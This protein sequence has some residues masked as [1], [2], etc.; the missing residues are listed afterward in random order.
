MSETVLEPLYLPIDLSI[1]LEARTADL[2]VEGVVTSTG[3]PIVNAFTGNDVQ[4]G[5]HR[6][7]GIEYRYAR[8]G[9]GN[10]AATGAIDLDFKDT[11]AHFNRLY[12]NQDGVIDHRVPS[13]A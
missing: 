4:A 2:A 10:A 7:D 3:R 8:M 11:Y 13:L 12:M 5:I 9:N 6:P 1:D